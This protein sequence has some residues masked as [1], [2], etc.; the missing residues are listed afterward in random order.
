MTHEGY[1]VDS[2]PQLLLVECNSM[3]SAPVPFVPAEGGGESCE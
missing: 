3:L 1:L 2:D